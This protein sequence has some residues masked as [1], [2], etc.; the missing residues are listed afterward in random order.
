MASITDTARAFFDIVETGQGWSAASA[1]CTPDASFASQA[2]PLAEIKT[3]QAY[4]EWMRALLG[5][6]PD[7]RY[8]LRSFATDDERA[9]VSAYAVFSGTHS[10]EGG[11][12]PATGKGTETD[13]VYVMQFANGK[14]RHMTKIWNAGWAMRELG[15]T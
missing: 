3:V 1:H 5:F 6:I 13:Y 10:G 2:E 15:W 7:G 9:T 8:E 11:P 4:A 14:I 12:C